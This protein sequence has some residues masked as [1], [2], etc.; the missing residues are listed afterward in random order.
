MISVEK[1]INVLHEQL[2]N[3]LLIQS[4]GFNPRYSTDIQNFK[5]LFFYPYD[6]STL[7]QV[8]GKCNW[9]HEEPLNYK[10]LLDLQYN[11]VFKSFTVDYSSA[12]YNITPGTPEQLPGYCFLFD[13]NFHLFANSEISSLK[14]DFL[15][16][17][18]VYD[19][20]FFF[21]GFAA[22]DWFRDYK[23]L[24]FS[25]Y[26]LDKV[27]ICLN[28]LIT[29]NRSYRLNLL[30]HI[31]ERK[32]D[33]SG[34][35]SAPLLTKDLI[36]QEL[37]DPYSRLSLTTKKHILNHLIPAAEPMVLDICDYN[38]ASADI[39]HDYIHSSLW[40][41]VTETNYYDDKLHLT[42]KIF[43]PI[44]TKHP[45]ILV[46][47]P[48]NLSYLKG[49]GFKTF[50]QWIDESY[51]SEPDPDLRIKMITNELQKLCNMPWE[52]LMQMRKEMDEVL[53][54]N[55]QHF[56]GK[57]REIIVNELVDNFEGC[58]NKYNLH[59]SD[60]RKIPK[61]LL[62]FNKVKKLLLS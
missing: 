51:D 29:N 61:Q 52:D 20:Y 2:L 19:W 54:Y 15:K 11:D 27:F 22:L 3:P 42:E 17:W 7:G 62:D 31:K 60:Y 6:Q 56:F 40:N 35:I 46:S 10:D 4:F 36:K 43:K 16:K 32:L 25:H 39:C 53:E 38:H 5:Q 34:Y 21:H 41:V 33:Q 26:K 12:E 57:F 9:W 30:S 14:K 45:F 47:S 28:H 18:K 48:G 55:H 58:I 23:Y 37:A 59:L 44:V 49:Y 1:F 8:N 50:D 13:C 24:T